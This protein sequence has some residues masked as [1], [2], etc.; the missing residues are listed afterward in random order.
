[1]KRILSLVLTFILLFT[2]FSFVGCKDEYER[3]ID[4]ADYVVVI[5]TEATT[6]ERYAAENFVSLVKS[7]IGVAL[8]IV[9]DSCPE[10]EREFLIGSTSRSESKTISPLNKGEYL[11][12]ARN[13]KIVM[14]GNGIYVGAS[15]GNFINEFA[16][17]KDGSTVLDITSVPKQEKVFTYSAKQ[18]ATSVIFMIG[19]GMGENHIS[20]AE[21]KGLNEF[22]AREFLY[23]GTSIT[24]S[25]SVI[26]KEAEYTDSAA[27]AT[28]MATGYKTLNRYIG[29]DKNGASLLNVRELA[30]SFGAKTG[31]I[32][33][34]VITGA[35]PSSYMC[36][37]NERDD[38]EIL[39]AQ[40]DA[41]VNEKKID[42]CSGSV[43][44][45]LT[46]EVKNALS[47]FSSSESFFLMVE[48][49]LIDK[50][51]HSKKQA[52][53]IEYV[54]RFDDAIEYATQFALCHPE[55]ALIVTADHETGKLTKSTS[56]YGYSFLSYNHTNKDVPIFALGAG[57][58]IF[59]GSRIENIELAKFCASAYTTEA[60]GQA[61]P[62]D[63]VQE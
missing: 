51:S 59:D 3:E 11:L 46:T 10:A 23:G 52:D 29:I 55:V 1:M 37:H 5:P 57:T 14:Q 54:K 24:R 19:D 26:N 8:S 2:L 40:I 42:Y 16:I 32:T 44:N 4:I 31:I 34:D 30:H 13:K 36:H 62:I 27:S 21:Y 58:S 48:E 25:Q 49:G 7:K 35:T 47:L 12:F 53:A 43:G 15:C 18:K 20:M 17:I 50:A 9:N 6:T 63:A 41:L 28:A 60:F 33:T 39:Q 22:V 56:K 61:E 45:E 38:A